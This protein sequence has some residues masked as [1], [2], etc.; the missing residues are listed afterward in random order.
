MQRCLAAMFMAAFSVLEGNKVS[1]I[2]SLEPPPSVQEDSI[3]SLVA[4]VKGDDIPMESQDGSAS[5]EQPDSIA[6]LVAVVKGNN[7]NMIVQDGF[8][9]SPG[10]APAPGPSAP[11]SAPETAPGN[12]PG[13]AS[14][15]VVAASPFGAEE[16]MGKTH[17]PAEGDAKFTKRLRGVDYYL[18]SAN[19][20]LKKSF[21]S[22]VKV[23]LAAQV[24]GGLEPRDVTLNLSA[25]SVIINASFA[26]PQNLSSL[27]QEKLIANL[28]SNEANVDADLLAAVS[29]L[30]GFKDTTTNTLSFDK[31]PH[32]KSKKAAPTMGAKPRASPSAQKALKEH[33]ISYNSV[34]DPPCMQGRGICGDGVCFCEDPYTGLQCEDQVQAAATRVNW[35]YVIP[36]IFVAGWLGILLAEV[37]WR[38]CLGPDRDTRGAPKEL[39]QGKTLV[40]HEIWKPLCWKSTEN[41]H[42]AFT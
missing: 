42:I 8:E 13:P 22:A 27:T 33:S 36:I 18:L 5:S 21:E 35:M 15:Q 10:P 29:N 40:R 16:E 1:D 30:P 20:A 3:A 34:C 7:E 41:S 12:A 37:M 32:C 24:A 9:V 14:L 39:G 28:C 4:A 6:S 17:M 38:T 2:D 19:L 25:G 26:N 31:S 11:A 23:V